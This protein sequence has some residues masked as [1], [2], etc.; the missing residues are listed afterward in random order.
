M[1]WLGLTSPIMS[2]GKVDSVWAARHAIVAI[3]G[4]LSETITMQLGAQG[5]NGGTFDIPISSS[6]GETNGNG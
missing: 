3:I 4:T 6:D 1:S 2:V 5:N